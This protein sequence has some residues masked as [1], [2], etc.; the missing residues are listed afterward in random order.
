M[1]YHY[2]CVY[3]LEIKAVKM[4]IIEVFSIALH[5]SYRLKCAVLLFSSSTVAS[6]LWVSCLDLI[7]FP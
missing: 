6:V 2:V 4:D 7:F 1:R 5:C 3:I